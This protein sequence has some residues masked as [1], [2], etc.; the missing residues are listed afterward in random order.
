MENAPVILTATM[1]AADQMFFNRLRQAHF[2]AER[3]FLDAHITLFHHLPPMALPE[4]KARIAA[5]TRELP[6]PVAAVTGLI[7]L[8]RGVAYKVESQDLMAIRDDLADAFHGLLTPQDQARPRLH[9]TV[10]NKV[11]PA[12]AR[13]LLSQLSRNFVERP[14]AICGISAFHYLGGPWAPVGQWQFRGKSR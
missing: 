6:P 2:P 9:I 11:E 5:F 12:E 7:N 10:Q 13:A 8:G 4:I 1:A 3:N 14:L